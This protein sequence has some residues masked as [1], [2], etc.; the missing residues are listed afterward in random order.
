MHI[1][2][3]APT[4]QSPPRQPTYTQS[5]SRSQSVATH[6]TPPIPHVTSIRAEED[7]EGADE[8]GEAPRQLAKQVR[9][10]APIQPPSSVRESPPPQPT[11]CSEPFLLLE[12]EDDTEDADW[13]G[14][15]GST[16]SDSVSEVEAEEEVDDSQA[17]TGAGSREAKAQERMDAAIVALN[18]AWTA[19]CTCGKAWHDFL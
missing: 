7:D 12:E 18:D 15:I 17:D 10:I 9:L 11:E 19:R 4:P 5:R 13:I 14:A 6:T 3:G 1:D 8:G 2:A 16:I